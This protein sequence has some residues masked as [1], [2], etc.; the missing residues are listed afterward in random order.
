MISRSRHPSTT[1]NFNTVGQVHSADW[2]SPDR[3]VLIEELEERRSAA[4][5]KRKWRRPRAA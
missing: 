4:K 2:R 3:Q 1:Q 5:A